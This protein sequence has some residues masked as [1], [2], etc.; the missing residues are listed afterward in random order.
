L[1]DGD[2]DTFDIPG[3][4]TS[5]QS[6]YLDGAL[7]GSGYTI[8]TGGGVSS[9]D[10]VQFTSPPDIGVEISCSFTGLLR[11]RC[12]YAQDKLSREQFLE[13]MYKTGVELKG[14]TP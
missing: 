1:G 13:Y 6:I 5:S 10:R 14:L 9:S 4:S 8:L 12:R 11:I 7:Q 2:E 3:K